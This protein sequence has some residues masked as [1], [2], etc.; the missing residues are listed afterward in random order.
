[1]SIILTLTFH[2]SYRKVIRLS[3]RELDKKCNAQKKNDFL[4]AWKLIQELPPDNPN[5]FWS[6]ATYHGMPFKQ[7]RVPLGGDESEGDSSGTGNDEKTWGGY[8]QHG[9]VLFPFWHRFYCLRLEQALQTVLEKGKERVALHYWDASSKESMF[10]GLP[11][12]VTDEHVYIDG[13]YVPNPLFKFKLPKP[14]EDDVSNDDQYSQFYVKKAGY[15]T[16]RYPYS[17]IRN[18]PDAKIVAKAHNKS[19][20]QMNETPLSLLQTNIIRCLNKGIT[21]PDS[22]HDSVAE[23]LKKCLDVTHYNPFS[24]TTSSAKHPP[25]IFQLSTRIMI[26]I[27][28]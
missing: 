5:S 7:R 14:I 26:Y 18:P 23:Q 6:I 15:K 3:L 19:I 12:I 17:G 4:K 20:D 28:P 21:T 2:F 10:E 11:H 24:N 8:C 13:E 1:M 25:L 9:N 16:C 22:H 27:W